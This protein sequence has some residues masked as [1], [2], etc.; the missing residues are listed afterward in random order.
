MFLNLLSLLVGFLCLLLV[1]LMVFN[2]KAN[3]KTNIYLVFILF[4]AGIQR[5]LNAIEILNLTEQTYSPLKIRPTIAFFIIPI[6]YLFFQRLLKENVKYYKE[7]LHFIAPILLFLTNIFILDSSISHYVYSVFSCSYFLGILFMVFHF[8]K[9]KN[10]SLIEKGSYAAIR[11]WTLLMT[12]ITFTLVLASNFFLLNEID[13]VVYLNNFYRYSSILWLIALGY[14]LKNP[15]IIFGAQQLLKNI[16][17]NE[18]QE[19]LTWSTTPLKP[20]EE[21]DKLLHTNILEKIG[22]IILS[23]QDCQKSTELLTT[24]TFNT[25]ALAKE[26]KIPKSHVEIIFKYYCHYSVN[27]FSNLVKVSYAISLIKNGYLERFT[28]AHL[29]VACLF[30]SRFTFSKNFKKFTGVSV[31]DFLLSQTTDIN[32]AANLLIINSKNIK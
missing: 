14:I 9:D 23:I 30:N 12:I 27:D 19:F 15:V 8:I 11:T 4:I 20:I 2:T 17:S 32:S 24:M 18:P 13:S 29:G 16:Q 7:L 3:R 28:I 22:P 6:Y 10:R 21:K 26:L 25:Q 1:I 5:F 31:S